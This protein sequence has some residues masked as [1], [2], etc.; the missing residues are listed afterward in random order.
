[1][2]RAF[3]VSAHRWAGLAMTGFL[4]IVGLTGSVLAFRE[5]LDVWLNP[6]LLTVA[7]RDARPLDPIVLRERAA[8][9]YPDARIDELPLHIEPGRSFELRIQR[10]RPEGGP[11]TTFVLLDPHTGE[12]LGARDWGAVS[13]A[14]QDILLFLY[15]LHYTLALPAWTGRFGVYLLGVVAF[16]WTIDCFVS[17]YLTF[18]LRRAQ[19]RA[20]PALQKSWWSRWRP[21]WA[22]KRGAG[23]YRVNLDIHRAFGLWTWAMLFIFAWSSVGFNL[24]EVH[25][26]TMNA[27]FGLAP[28]ALR[29][30]LRATPLDHP[31]L[32]WRDARDV[33]RGLLDEQARAGGFAIVRE[34]FIAFDREHGAYTMSAHGSRDPGRR[35]GVSVTFD[36]ETGSLLRAVWPGRESEKTGDLITYWFAQ[37]H[38]AAVL[39]VP[40]KLFVCA[41]GLVI[42][43]LAVTGVYI[44]WKKRA[45]RTPHRRPAARTVA[46]PCGRLRS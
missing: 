39:G 19:P 22:I 46:V 36:A 37:L 3:W 15:R 34:A 14:R 24:K 42:A 12:R 38:T 28:A 29:P 7:T 31:R 17:A 27:L 2:R 13:L 40:M 35:A 43:T 33:G 8:A 20:A 9:L 18:P 4:V 41:M 44:W 32:D 23:A 11:R 5:E 26:P 16:V 1:M 25:A 30:P 6:E 10:P 21:A 45:A